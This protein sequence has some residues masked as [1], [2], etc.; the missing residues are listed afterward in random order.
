MRRQATSVKQSKSTSCPISTSSDVPI[1]GSQV[2]NS[3]I[4]QPDASQAHSSLGSLIPNPFQHVSASS[5]PP[6]SKNASE[7]GR[8]N[9]PRVRRFHLS[10]ASL[11]TPSRSISSV[12]G[13]HKSHRGSKKQ[14][15]VFE[16]VSKRLYNE[17]TGSESW[18]HL[19]NA[20]N[21][22]NGQ[23]ELERTIAEPVD[24]K[25]PQATAEERAWRT[26]NWASPKNAEVAPKVDQR[27]IIAVPP[28]TDGD[29]ASLQLAQELQKFAM[30]TSSAQ[31]NMPQGGHLPTST[32]SV[33]RP[34]KFKPKPPKIRHPGKDPVAETV[35]DVENA[36]GKSG[37]DETSYVVDTYIRADP[38]A[39]DLSRYWSAKDQSSDSKI[40]IIV[41]DEEAEAVWE[42]FADD[43][44]SDPEADSEEED[45]NGLMHYPRLMKCRRLTQGSR[46]L[47]R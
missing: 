16:E 41:I 5:L 13:I 3:P 7:L 20:S 33:A 40:G 43:C 6:Q 23:L 47:L 30:E 21:K 18:K 9:D 38:Q 24:R 32:A 31:T 25:R 39:V 22:H 14:L 28:S 19:R 36:I 45:E 8:A 46:G 11:R 17:N 37:L 10:H 15:A 29:D 4:T 35:M 44:A 2:N 12:S 26:R 34:L 27:E 1:L 42:T